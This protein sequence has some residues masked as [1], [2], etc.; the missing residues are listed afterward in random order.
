VNIATRGRVQTGD[1]VMIAGFALGG[2][3][4]Q[5]VIV[6]ARGPS[7]AQAGVSGVLANPRLQLLRDGVVLASNDDWQQAANA[8]DIEASGFAPLDPSES[9]IMM[10]LGTGLYTAVVRG[11]GETAGVAIIE[12]FRK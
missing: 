9:A 5:T 1:D 12:V 7:L 4:P 2:S 10:T 3:A 8:A 11:V 6:R